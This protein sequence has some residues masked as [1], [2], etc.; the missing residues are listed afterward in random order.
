ML[1]FSRWKALA[2]LLTAFVVCLLA[3]P[4]FFSDATLKSLPAW[5][6]RHVVLGLARHGARVTPD[7]RV[8]VDEESVPRHVLFVVLPPTRRQWTRRIRVF[9]TVGLVTC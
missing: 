9:Q 5:A 2:T 8:L 3:V 6:Q 4:N 1:Y 7:A